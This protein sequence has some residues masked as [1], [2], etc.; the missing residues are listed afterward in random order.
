MK[1]SSSIRGLFW[2]D[3]ARLIRLLHK[4]DHDPLDHCFPSD[5][6][7]QMIKIS[8]FT[9]LLIFQVTVKLPYIN[10]RKPTVNSFNVSEVLTKWD[11]HIKLC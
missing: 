3:V 6:H 5:F 11:I 9:E 8:T 7:L 1:V 10:V 2:R 4:P